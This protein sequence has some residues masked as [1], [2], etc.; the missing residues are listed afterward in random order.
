MIN[1][2]LSE[3][4]NIDSMDR[5]EIQFHVIFCKTFL[6]NGDYSKATGL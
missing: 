5:D 1:P 6:F 2:C 4:W 3:I